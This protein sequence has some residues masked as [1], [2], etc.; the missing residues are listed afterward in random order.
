MLGSLLTAGSSLFHRCNDGSNCLDGNYKVISK[1]TIYSPTVCSG[2]ED[3]NFFHKSTGFNGGCVECS[4]CAFDEVKT[5]TCSTAHDRKCEKM[6]STTSEIW[7]PSKYNYTQTKETGIVSLFFL[8]FA[9]FLSPLS[10]HSFRYYNRDLKIRLR[11][12]QRELQKSNRFNWLEKQRFC[13][14]ITLFCTFLCPS[15]HGYEAWKCLISQRKYT[16][17]SEISPLFLNLDMVFWN[18]TLGGFVYIWQI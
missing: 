11:R 12:R 3:G 5:R 8:L 2:C 16:S 4:K 18:S 7:A 9:Y 13:T 14:C 6:P 10:F 1:C 17:D 15:L